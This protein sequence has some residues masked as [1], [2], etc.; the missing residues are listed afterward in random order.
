MKHAQAH[1]QLLTLD[2]CDLWKFIDPLHNGQLSTVAAR[3]YMLDMILVTLD[4]LAVIPLLLLLL[5]LL[6]T[7]VVLGWQSPS[8]EQRQ[9]PIWPPLILL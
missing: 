5:L 9:L 2:T 3:Q 4:A 6:L 7:G 1:G 8:F